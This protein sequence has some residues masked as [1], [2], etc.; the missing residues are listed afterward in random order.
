MER[1]ENNE[2]V[3]VVVADSKIARLKVGKVE[4]RVGPNYFLVQLHLNNRILYK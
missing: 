1:E 3:G 4:T 2:I